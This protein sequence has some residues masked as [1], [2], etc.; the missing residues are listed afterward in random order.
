MAVL[1]Q[2]FNKI[3]KF[4]FY[5]KEVYLQ[6]KGVQW[7]RSETWQW[8]W[9]WSW[10]QVPGCMP[11]ADQQGHSLH[12]HPQHWLH[13]QPLPGHQGKG[14]EGGFHHPPG[15]EETESKHTQKKCSEK[16]NSLAER[17]LGKNMQTPSLLI[18][19]FN[20]VMKRR[21]LSATNVIKSSS[22]TTPMECI[23]VKY[24]IKCWLV[25]RV[26]ILQRMLTTWNSTK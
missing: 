9:G 4:M 25:M 17:E 26:I 11:G 14:E 19:K 23:L 13:P 18:A 6:K 8:Q 7:A 2:I 21:S 12:L 15:Q 24:T 10:H 3:I 16:E 5:P 22:V 1:K 20:L